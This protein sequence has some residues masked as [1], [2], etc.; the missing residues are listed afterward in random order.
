MRKEDLLPLFLVIEL[1]TP[2]PEPRWA[3]A[4]SP[5]SSGHLTPLTHSGYCSLWKLPSELMLTVISLQ[6]PGRVANSIYTHTQAHTKAHTY[7]HACS[8]THTHHFISSSPLFRYTLYR[9]LT[10]GPAS[11]CSCLRTPK[12]LRHSWHPQWYEYLKEG[13]AQQ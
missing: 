5:V 7:M 13:T 11:C 3:S 1:G 6:L 8:H 9:S 2:E 10:R 4:S 12:R